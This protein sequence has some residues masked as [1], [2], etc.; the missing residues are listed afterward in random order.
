ML[1]YIS[2]L[3]CPDGIGCS[4]GF[5]RSTGIGTFSERDLCVPQTLGRTMAPVVFESVY[6]K[7]RHFNAHERLEAMVDDRR[8]M[9]GKGVALSGVVPG[10]DE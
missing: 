6:N 9:L 2:A 3:N 4:N 5:P 1:V 7:G 8:K 10:K